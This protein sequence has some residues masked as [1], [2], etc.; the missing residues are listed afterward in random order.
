MNWLIV[1][2][3]YIVSVLHYED[4]GL[5]EFTEYEYK[6]RAQNQFGSTTS[7]AVRYRTMQGTP[8]NDSVLRVYNIKARSAEFGWTLP[9]DINGYIGS[10]TLISTNLRQPAEHNWWT[11]SKNK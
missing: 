10:Y 4:T 2:L 9:S 7:P 11:V 8:T 1:E 6:V 3:I 5:K